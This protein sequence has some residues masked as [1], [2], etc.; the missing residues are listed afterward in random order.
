MPKQIFKTKSQYKLKEIMR[1]KKLFL[2]AIFVSILHLTLLYFRY[3]FRT[4]DMNLIDL[5]Q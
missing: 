1:I 4:M 3:K 5:Q 2:I